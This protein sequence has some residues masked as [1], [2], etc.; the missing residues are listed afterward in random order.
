MDGTSEVP[1]S[2]S[3]AAY[4]VPEQPEGEAGRGARVHGRALGTTS[5]ADMDGAPHCHCSPHR[6]DCSTLGNECDSMP[7]TCSP[8]TL[9]CTTAFLLFGAQCHGRIPV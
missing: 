4:R 9:R 7:P 8:Y 6:K 2:R 3:D 1:S 5:V